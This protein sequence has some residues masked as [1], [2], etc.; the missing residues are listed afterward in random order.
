LDHSIVGSEVTDELLKTSYEYFNAAA[1]V[2]KGKTHKTCDDAVLLVANENFALIG[3]FDGVSGEAFAANASETALRVIKFFITQNFGKIDNEKIIERSIEEANLK[4]NKGATTASIALL[5]ANGEYFFGNIGDSHIYT[6]SERGKIECITK[7]EKEANGSSFT[8]YINSRFIVNNA[9]GGLIRNLDIGKGKLKKGE[10]LLAMSDG[11]IDNLFI[12]ID[13]GVIVDNSGA[14]DLENMIKGKHEPVDIIIALSN[15]IK[16]RMSG[17]EI[18]NNGK[19]LVPK[20][21]DVSVVVLKYQP[22]NF[23]NAPR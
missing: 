21:D 10:F 17:T 22:L 9:L 2:R 19:I 1:Y 4:I 20:E 3:V 5:L 23:T 11:V 8:E 13:S 14:R 18:I 6:I 16:N 7:D 12:E 15:E